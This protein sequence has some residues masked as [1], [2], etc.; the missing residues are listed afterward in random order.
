MKKGDKVF[1][2]KDY[3]SIGKIVN[4]KGKIYTIISCYS[5]YNT[6]YISVDTNYQYGNLCNKNDFI[7]G[8]ETPEYKFFDYFIDLKESRKQKLKK[9]KTL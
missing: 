4:T 9:L 2:I 5:R 7:L 1:C 6:W 8:S 3:I